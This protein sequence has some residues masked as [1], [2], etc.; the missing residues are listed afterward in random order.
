MPRCHRGRSFSAAERASRIAIYRPGSIED[1]PQVLEE[2]K[3]WG[4]ERLL[5]FR[6]ATTPY[7]RLP[8]RSDYGLI[9]EAVLAADSVREQRD[10]DG[11]RGMRSRRRM[12][13]GEEVGRGIERVSLKAAPF[14]V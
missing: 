13:A 9:D 1:S 6:N 4:I 11:I 12:A 14:P 8:C 5:R 3:D 2:I 7:I 10:S